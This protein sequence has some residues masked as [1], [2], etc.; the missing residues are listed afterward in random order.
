MQEWN[1]LRPP[2]RTA[3]GARALLRL[4]QQQLLLLL[5]LAGAPVH[6]LPKLSQGGWEARDGDRLRGRSYSTPMPSLSTTA[7][8]SE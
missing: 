3:L 2:R 1:V 5:P 8:L 4:Q 6:R 7:L